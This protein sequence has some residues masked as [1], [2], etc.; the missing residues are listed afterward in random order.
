MEN[1]IPRLKTKY[2]NEVVPKLME[3]F[4]YTSVMQAPRLLK[5]CVN[6]GVGE[7]T[8]D[9]KMIDVAAKEMTTITGQKAVPTIARKAI[10]NFKL[11]EFIP[12]GVKVTL[13]GERMWEFLDRLLAVALPRVRDFQGVND[14]SFDGR[15]NYTLGVTEQIIFPEIDLDKITKLMGMDIS[16]VTSAQTDKEAYALLLHLGMPFKNKNTKQQ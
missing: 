15:G 16:F 14:K 7:A 6:Q 13:R 5:I 3:E 8:Q 4:S 12:I 2:R 10:S 9:K 1:Y 11:R